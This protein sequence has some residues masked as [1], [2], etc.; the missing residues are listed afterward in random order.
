M[1]LSN[2]LLQV[3]VS[4]NWQ[5]LPDVVGGYSVRSAYQVPTSQDSPT[6]HISESLIWHSKAS[7]KV[8]IL[9]WRLLRDRLPTKNNLLACGIITGA[10]TSCLAGCGQVETAQHLFLHC[11]LSGSLW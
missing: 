5:W 10:N 7:L 8:S 11:G 2:V 4:D 9:V 3:N 6:L 1:L